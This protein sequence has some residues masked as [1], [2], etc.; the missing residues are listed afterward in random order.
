MKE[1]QIVG[2]MLIKDEDLYIEWVIRNVIDFCDQLIIAENYSKDR[3]YEIVSTL[4][5][6][7][8]NITVHRVRELQESHKLIAD[9]A[10][11]DTWAFRIDGD[12]IYDPEGLVK[13]RQYLDTGVFR[14][15]WCIA[16]NMLNCTSFDVNSKTAKGYLSPPS[17]PGMALY[18]FS[19]INSWEN[20]YQ[21]THGG[22]VHF[23]DG[24]HAELRCVLGKQMSWEESYFRC[25]HT[26]FVKR[27]SLQKNLL[28]RSRWNS[29]EMDRKKRNYLKEFTKQYPFRGSS[30][31]AKMLWT[32]KLLFRKDWKHE[33]YAKG[34][35]VEKDISAFFR[36]HDAS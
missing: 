5:E 9:F 6:T 20:C 35:L 30:W 32:S 13:M 36:S 11:S 14:E 31:L 34:A 23:K 15:Q 33:Q 17:R 26:V 16:G 10:G 22:T 3:T 24:Y 28:V 4:A 18:N 21:R 27:S 2:I 7:H 29:S 19:L 12:E 8:S 25:L 1:V